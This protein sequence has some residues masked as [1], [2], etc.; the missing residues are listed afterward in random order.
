MTVEK[1]SKVHPFNFFPSFIVNL[2]VRFYLEKFHQTSQ[3]RQF[4]INQ[5]HR[6]TQRKEES[7][8]EFHSVSSSISLSDTLQLQL[9]E[10]SDV[11]IK[12]YQA[13]GLTSL[14]F[15]YDSYEQDSL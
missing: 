11:L 4:R 15:I 8:K 10:L 5:K 7:D 13:A 14:S 6:Q 3:Q 12:F 1:Y 2:S 9:Q